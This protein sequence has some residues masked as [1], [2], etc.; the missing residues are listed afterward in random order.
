VANETYNPNKLTRNARGEC[1]KNAKNATNT[2]EKGDGRVGG[3]RGNCA[4][5]HFSLTKNDLK[6]ETSVTRWGQHKT[7]AI[8]IYGKRIQKSFNNKSE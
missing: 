5:V 2:K 7:R 3:R 1:N 6:I 8:S 4:G